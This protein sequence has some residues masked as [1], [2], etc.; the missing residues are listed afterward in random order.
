LRTAQ[1]PELQTLNNRLT[2]EEIH[3]L[4]ATGETTPSEICRQALDRIDQTNG[5]LNA[6]VDRYP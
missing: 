5:R 3:R 1:Y 2:I 6:P 4:Y